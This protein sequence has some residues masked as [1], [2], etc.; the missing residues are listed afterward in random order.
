MEIR[1]ATLNDLEYLIDFACEEAREAE[2]ITK[3]KSILKNGIRPAL[4]D[5]G[6]AMYWVLVDEGETP[7]G[8]ISSLKE[9]SNWNA[10]Y[11]WWIQSMY[12]KPDHRGKGWLKEMIATVK[13]EMLS[14]KGLELKL[15][16]HKENAAAKKAYYKV[17]F[18]DTNYDIMKLES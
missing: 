5:P 15:Q 14:Q 16:V 9:W 18:I 13:T 6:I 4:E 12:I 1:R 17:G 10:G 11:Y 7:V 8:N 2:G 3:D